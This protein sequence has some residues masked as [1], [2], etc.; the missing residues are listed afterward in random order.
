MSDSEYSTGYPRKKTHNKL[1]QHHKHGIMKTKARSKMLNKNLWEMYQTLPHTNKQIAQQIGINTG[2][3]KRW[4]KLQQVPND[5]YFDFC[6]MLKIQPDLSDYTYAE[7]DQFFTKPETAK[8]CIDTAQ[9]IIQKFGDNPKEYTHIEPSAG[10]GAFYT[11]LPQ[12]KI[13]IDIEPKVDGVTAGDYL[14]WQPQKSEKYIVIGN[15]PFGLR[16]HTAL[17]FINRSQHAHYIAFILPQTFDSNGKGSTKRRVKGFNLLHTEKIPN[18]FIYP[19]GK[20]VSV[21][22]VFQIWSKH[23]KIEEETIDISDKIKIYSLSDGGTPGST[24]NKNKLYTCNYYL[25]STVFG[26]NKMKLYYNFEDLPGRRGYGIVTKDNTTN[27]IIENITW[28]KEALV[29][30]NNAYNLRFDIIEK[31]IAKNCLFVA[32]AENTP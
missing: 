8:H 20:D 19:D 28:D 18:A 30:T 25:P 17:N 24:R 22:C 2:T 29:S 16:G 27:N 1:T 23:H 4:E 14:T 13:G 11:Q 12:P 15:P 5:Y 26:I 7:K 9:K 31:S 3:I 32:T 21:N 6:R 10:D